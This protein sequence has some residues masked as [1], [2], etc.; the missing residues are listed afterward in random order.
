MANLTDPDPLRNACRWCAAPLQAG[1]RFCPFCGKEQPGAELA[2]G[3]VPVERSGRAPRFL[4]LASA[5][6]ELDFADT[7]Q[8]D[9]DEAIGYADPGTADAAVVDVRDRPGELPSLP[10]LKDLNAIPQA[11][12]PSGIRRWLA[13]AI[14]SLALVALSVALIHATLGPPDEPA[15]DAR[16]TVAK[17]SANATVAPS[18][19]RPPA[20]R[21]PA[22][23]PAAAP[24]AVGALPPAP[25]TAP[26]AAPS[27]SASPS[28]SPSPSPATLAAA[29][30]AA[31]TDA[32]ARP[33]STAT[34]ASPAAAPP[35]PTDPPSDD[36]PPKACAQALAALSLC[37]NP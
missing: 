2:A 27:A 32:P 18:V 22:G 25:A 37:P 5:P 4:P 6:V 1:G 36:P 15:A 9:E 34:S 31:A 35:P 13:G 16:V 21:A 8:P 23:A 10:A 26:D 20:D 30:A 14:G 19:A 24:A 11:R 33:S 3:S 17:A 28:P 29:A 7:V 12:S